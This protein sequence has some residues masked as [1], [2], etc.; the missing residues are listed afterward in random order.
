MKRNRLF[1]LQLLSSPGQLKYAV[2]GSVVV[3]LHQFTV[4]KPTRRK[5]AWRQL[6]SGQSGPHLH[7]L[8]PLSQGKKGFHGTQLSACQVKKDWEVPYSRP[9]QTLKGIRLWGSHMIPGRI[10]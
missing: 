2:L 9:L 3:V 6:E 1:Y 10:N 5:L 7:M 4:E 8:C